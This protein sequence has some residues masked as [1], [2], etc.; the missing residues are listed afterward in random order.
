MRV[1]LL[2]VDEQSTK[3]TVNDT[4][5]ERPP[6]TVPLAGLMVMPLI[7]LLVAD[8]FNSPWS[9]ELVPRLN[10]QFQPLLKLQSLLALNEVLSAVSVGV[11][12]VQAAGTVTPAIVKVRVTL[13]LQ[14][15]SGIKMLTLAVCP[16]VSVP[17]AGSKLIGVLPK[18]GAEADQLKLLGTL[19]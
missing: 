1:A 9:P 5:V 16:E 19:A 11:A 7:P 2:L 3:G 18:D 10:L 8:Q 6:A 17:P 15:T 12:H 14:A 13:A 4:C